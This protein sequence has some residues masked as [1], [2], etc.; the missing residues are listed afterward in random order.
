MK[1]L[2]DYAGKYQ[3]CRFVIVGKGPTKFQFENLAEIGDPVIFI[4]DAVQFDHM[5]E[6]SV[7]TFFFAL[8]AKQA[9]WLEP[10]MRSTPVLSIRP[11]TQYMT[12]HGDIAHERLFLCDLPTAR[13]PDCV[14]YRWGRA[15]DIDNF[16]PRSLLFDQLLIGHKGTIIPAIH[17]AW[18]CGASEIAF[19]G[20]DG[21]PNG[22]DARIEIKSGAPDL[23]VNAIIRKNQDALCERLDLPTVYVDTESLEPVI[24]KRMNFAWFGSEP[25]EWVRDIVSLFELHHPGWFTRIH[26]EFQEDMLSC[27]WFKEAVDKCWQFCQQ[28]DLLYLWLLYNEGGFVMDTDSVTIRSFEPLR[29]GHSA[30]TTCHLAWGN[31]LTNGVMGSVPR[32]RAFARCVRH[33]G[34]RARTGWPRDKHGQLPRCSFGPTMLTELFTEQGD[35]DMTIL[36]HWYFYPFRTTD[37]GMAMEFW[38]AGEERRRELLGQLGESIPDGQIPFAAHMWGVDGSGHTPVEGLPRILNGVAI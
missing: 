25:P 19:I 32:G 23:G 7:E 27:S 35:G 28:A 20:C 3:G 4:N 10:G 1:P 29:R 18:L 37:R 22:Y 2:S 15:P 33:I 31:R 26:T 9:V 6:R 30:F 8:D 24:P 12:E 11:D 14:G 36:P 5:A 34:Q 38:H 21:I 13:I 16:N 17:F